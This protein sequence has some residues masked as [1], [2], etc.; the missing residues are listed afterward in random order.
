MD[1]CLKEWGDF[2]HVNCIKNKMLIQIFSRIIIILYLFT[3]VI[4]FKIFIYPSFSC[5]FLR[6]SYHAFSSTG[7]Y[8][9]IR[10]CH[11]QGDNGDDGAPGPPGAVGPP[12]PRG[13]PGM[14]G[15]PG[16]KGHRGFPGMDGSKG[17]QGM[18]GDKG[19]SGPSGPP[20]PIGPMV[21]KRAL[22]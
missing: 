15:L 22:S 7:L 20:G 17:D 4:D 14:P 13:L 5:S 19:A 18:M 11:C 8:N 2:L 1:I 9:N 21:S 16:V 3:T 12:G 6:I 10:Y